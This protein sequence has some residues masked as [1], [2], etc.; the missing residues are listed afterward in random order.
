MFGQNLVRGFRGECSSEN[1]D[2]KRSIHD[3]RHK[4]NKR[5]VTVAHHEHFVLS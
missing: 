1:D 2:A 3:G 4:T 5:P